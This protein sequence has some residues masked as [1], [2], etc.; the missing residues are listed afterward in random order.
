M[1]RTILLCLLATCAF[2]A[3]GSVEPDAKPAPE[4]KVEPAKQVT[5]DDLQNLAACARMTM[6]NLTPDQM[7]T[8]ALAIKHAE[9]DI[10]AMRKAAAVPVEVKK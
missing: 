9:A 6:Q 4:V 5:A 8:V 10:E 1:L 3:E 2:S 7:A